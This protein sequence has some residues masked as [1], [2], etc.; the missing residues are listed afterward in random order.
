[1]FQFSFFTLTG[2]NC[3]ETHPF[4]GLNSTN[5]TVCFDECRQD[6]YLVYNS[7]YK[8]FVCTN[9]NMSHCKTCVA[10][11]KCNSCFDGYTFDSANYNCTLSPGYCLNS[12]N[13]SQKC[14]DA[15]TNCLNCS[16]NTTCTICKIGFFLNTSNLCSPCSNLT[17]DCTQCN[18]THCVNCALPKVLINA[19]LCSLPMDPQP[20]PTP[21]EVSV[22]CED[23]NCITCQTGNS[24]ICLR[25][26]SSL[27]EL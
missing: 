23:P 15:M 16:S 17:A 22:T 3:P 7:T 25:C 6:Q 4:R 8:S 11:G 19:T 20:L 21:N 10:A 18:S 9:C 14:G 26:S 5:H 13:Q 24:S 27:Y 2:K 12:Q 1:M